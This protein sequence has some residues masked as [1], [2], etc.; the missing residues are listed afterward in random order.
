MLFIDEGNETV[1]DVET[2]KLTA[3]EVVDALGYT[4]ADA[5][6]VS[7]LSQKIDNLDNY[8][9][10]EL[11]NVN[12]GY[13][14]GIA[15]EE[16]PT[17]SINKNRIGAEQYKTMLRLNLTNPT[18][19]AALRLKISN[20]L[21]RAANSE[22]IDD[23]T[24]GIS[25]KTGHRYVVKTMLLDGEVTIPSDGHVPYC[26]VIEAGT[27]VHAGTDITYN[28]YNA[29]TEYTA[30]SEQVNLVMRVCRGAM[31]KNAIYQIIMID[32]T[33]KLDDIVKY[34]QYPENTTWN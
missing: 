33:E 27:S 26:S 16:E 25:L 10:T 30:T 20:G 21:E 8:M 3:G 12:Y 19:N 4:P 34:T 17:S 2:D 15:I 28:D 14:N 13:G 1:P 24:E 9:N 23:W 31:I 6:D 18:P 11:Y 7:R 29:S 5:E 22:E 32:L